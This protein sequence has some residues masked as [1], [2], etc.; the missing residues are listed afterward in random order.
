MNIILQFLSDNE[1]LHSDLEDYFSW[2]LNIS[3]KILI[4]KT[5]SSTETHT[6]TRELC[7]SCDLLP[8]TMLSSFFNQITGE[9]LCV[10]TSLESVYLSRLTRK[11]LYHS[12]LPQSLCFPHDV[13]FA[14]CP[15][16]SLFTQICLLLTSPLCL[17]TWSASTQPWDTCCFMNHSFQP[18][19]KF[20]F[21][22]QLLYKHSFKTRLS[23]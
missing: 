9:V 6:C 21:P 4:H 18:I 5:W 15:W 17:S 7:D 12:S 11:T 2:V 22:E 14:I 3:S 10:L 13:S 8:C 20:T 16:R 23:L 1:H 19:L